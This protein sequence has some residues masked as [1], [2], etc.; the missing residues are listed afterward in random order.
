MSRHLVTILAAFLLLTLVP[1]VATAEDDPIVPARKAALAWLTLIDS[2]Q[3]EASYSVGGDALHQIITRDK[4]DVV[5]K[6][7]RPAIGTMTSRTEVKHL[8]QPNGIQGLSGQCMVI[9]YNTVF[10]GQD[11]G[12]EVVILHLENN[13]WRGVG[14]TVGPKPGTATAG[15]SPTAP[16]V[17]STSGTTHSNPQPQQS[18]SSPSPAGK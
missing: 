2:G 10:K 9:A 3:Y 11:E 5:L 14:Y 13:Q 15:P 6:T 7:L 17:Q 16:M 4:W 1:R 12:V 18:T 8:Y